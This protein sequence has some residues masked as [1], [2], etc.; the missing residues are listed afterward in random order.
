ML[1]MWMEWLLFILSDKKYFFEIFLCGFVH[2]N[3]PLGFLSTLQQKR[4]THAR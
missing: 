3:I 2:D 1:N 4:T